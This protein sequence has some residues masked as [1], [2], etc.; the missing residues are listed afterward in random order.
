MRLV[1]NWKRVARYSWS[2]WLNVAIT[3]AS[4]LEAGITYWADGR[5]SMSLIVGGVSLT[6]GVLRLIKQPEISGD[7]P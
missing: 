2:F 1:P 5:L 6:A 4:A 7:E 3:L